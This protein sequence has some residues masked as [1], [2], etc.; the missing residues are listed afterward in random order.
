MIGKGEVVVVIGFLGL[1]KS[2]FLCCF[3]LLEQF[4]LGEINF[5]GVLIMDFKYN[6]NV[7]WEKMGMVFQYFNLFF[8]LI[9]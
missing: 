2:I 7:M 1:G 8:Y 9:V 3:N 4:I 5:E 6:I